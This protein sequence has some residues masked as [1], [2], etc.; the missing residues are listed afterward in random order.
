MCYR[1]YASRGRRP[2]T[3]HIPRHCMSSVFHSQSNIVNFPQLFRQPLLFCK[4]I[5]DRNLLL[6]RAHRNS[7]WHVTGIDSSNIVGSFAHQTY[8]YPA[9]RSRDRRDYF[10]VVEVFMSF[11]VH[12]FPGCVA[13]VMR[14]VYPER[15]TRDLDTHV[16]RPDFGSI[17]PS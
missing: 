2:S 8:H 1:T 16:R 5:A 15:E 4:G 7:W 3:E 11:L 13:C 6:Y 17:G 14:H 10:P 9:S 12:S